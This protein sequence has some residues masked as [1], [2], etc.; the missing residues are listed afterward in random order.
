MVGQVGIRVGGGWVQRREGGREGEMRRGGQGGGEGVGGVRG[1]FSGKGNSWYK[2]PAED[3]LSWKECCTAMDEEVDSIQ[4]LQIVC[5]KFFIGGWG[6][7][8]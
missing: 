2:L 7:F 1:G 5:F 3:R 6:T 4:L 8:S